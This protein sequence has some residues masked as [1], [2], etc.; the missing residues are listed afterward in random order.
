MVT[1][2]WR[3]RS[4]REA[5]F[6]GTDEPEQHAEGAV[7]HSA[8]SGLDLDKAI[9]ALPPQ[10]RMVF[11]LYDIEGYRHREIARLAGLSVG[12]SK[13]HLHRARRLLRESLG[14]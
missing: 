8:A 5:R 2:E 13:A 14:S 7:G 4:R 10:A 9:R 12:T 1:S 11:V 6:V 3:S